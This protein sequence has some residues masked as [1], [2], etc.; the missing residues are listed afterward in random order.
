[1]EYGLPCAVKTAYLEVIMATLLTIALIAQIVLAVLL[2]VVVLLQ[3][4]KESGLGAISG[5]TSSYM[6]S[7]KSA[8]MDAKLAT[9]TKWIAAIFVVMTLAV[10]ILLRVVR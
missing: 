6:G 7:G 2:I 1:M 10:L 4:S 3:N 5:S 8:T 9:A